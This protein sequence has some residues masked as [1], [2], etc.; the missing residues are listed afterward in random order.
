M[1][2]TFLRGQPLKKVYIQDISLENNETIMSHHKLYGP[3]QKEKTL[4]IPM[5]I[6]VLLLSI[7]ARALKKREKKL[8]IV[9]FSR[10]ARFYLYNCFRIFPLGV[11][12]EKYLL[13]N[14]SFL[15]LPYVQKKGKKKLYS[16]S[17][18]KVHVNNILMRSV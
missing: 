2:Y 14:S 17:Y 11:A 6:N 9:F 4:C 12:V 13:I 16:L 8:F 7:G 1:P 15:N 18:L 5:V 10:R 3:H